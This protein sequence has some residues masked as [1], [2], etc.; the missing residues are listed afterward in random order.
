MGRMRAMI[1]HLFIAHVAFMALLPLAC[2]GSSGPANAS[3]FCQ[4]S[5]SI[6]CDKV[7]QCIPT[8]ARDQSFTDTFGSSVSECK[9]SK[10][11]ADCATMTS[12]TYN[13]SAAQACINALAPLT[14]SDIGNGNL[15][16][17]CDRACP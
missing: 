1:K 7:F 12:C 13:A 17:D 2:G 15:P 4:Q 9:T 16:P 6:L 14:C 3:E 5:E 10:V 11:P 8:A